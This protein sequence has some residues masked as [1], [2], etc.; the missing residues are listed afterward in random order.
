LW[1]RSPAA[2]F[3]NDNPALHDGSRWLCESLLG[4]PAAVL[5]GRS[6]PVSEKPADDFERLV[7]A[8]AELAGD[9]GPAVSAW[10]TK[11]TVA[12]NELPDRAAARLVEFGLVA[13]DGACLRAS[14]DFRT[15]A[16]AWRGVLGGAC[17]DWSGCGDEPLDEWAAGILARLLD[18]PGSEL[19]RELRARGVAAFGV[20]D[21]AA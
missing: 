10:M 11:G 17:Q 21:C 5:E 9:L 12:E 16:G 19:R 6:E 14:G 7:V 3:P 2:E 4:P 1:I 18:K 20:I 13:R 8:M 15:R